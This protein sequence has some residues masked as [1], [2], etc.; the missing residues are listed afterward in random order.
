M[1]NAEQIVSK[2]RVTDCRPGAAAEMMSV[3]RRGHQHGKRG[4]YTPAD[5]ST[6]NLD[7]YWGVGIDIE[8]LEESL[9]MR[10]GTLLRIYRDAFRAGARERVATTKSRKRAA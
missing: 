10:E 5:F 7:W 9:L 6:A 3:Q 8:L 1:L 4:A 2:C